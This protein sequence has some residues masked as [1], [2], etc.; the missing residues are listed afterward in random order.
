MQ[1]LQGPVSDQFIFW[2][3]LKVF[4]WKRFVTLAQLVL[5]SSIFLNLMTA[6]RKR[7]LHASLV[8]LQERTS[9]IKVPD[10][11]R[12]WTLLYWFIPIIAGLA[13]SLAMLMHWFVKVNG[14]AISFSEAWLG[15]AIILTL[16]CIPLAQ[17]IL[18]LSI[19]R[20]GVRGL[21]RN[22]PRL[23]AWLLHYERFDRNVTIIVFAL[24]ALVTALQ[25]Y[26]S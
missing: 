20:T 18:T 19:L 13:V 5:A 22:V 10:I 6:E 15:W 12:F 1:W 7:R 3:G 2:F 24:L 4:W 16:I 8:E 9:S 17:I 21:Q 26:L 11:I 14:H 23:A 25:I